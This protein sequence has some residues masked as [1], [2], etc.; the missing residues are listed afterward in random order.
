MS[1]IPPNSCN[2]TLLYILR[3]FGSHKGDERYDPRAD[4]FPPGAPDGLVNI[5]DFN[6]WRRECLGTPAGASKSPAT[7]TTIDLGEGLTVTVKWKATKG[8]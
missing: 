6:E 3:A 5:R 2:F 1:D 7:S 4:I 8:E